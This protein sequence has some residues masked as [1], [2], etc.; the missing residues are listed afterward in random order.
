VHFYLYVLKTQNT[1]V[2]KLQLNHDSGNS[3]VKEKLQKINLIKD[4]IDTGIYHYENGEY[5]TAEQ[6]LTYA[7]EV[8]L[9]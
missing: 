9:V 7:L 3:E 6:M 8:N 2:K 1:C 5:D 4:W